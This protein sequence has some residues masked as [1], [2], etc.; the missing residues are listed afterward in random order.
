MSSK[1]RRL[2]LGLIGLIGLGSVITFFAIPRT[3]Y[4]MIDLKVGNSS[5]QIVQKYIANLENEIKT[6]QKTD[7]YSNQKAIFL[8]ARLIT[9]NH[10]ILSNLK[11]AKT[12]FAFVTAYSLV[13]DSKENLEKNFNSALMTKTYRFS[14]NDD[15]NSD[16]TSDLTKIA[17]SDT[18]LFNQDGGYHQWSNKSD[19]TQ[20][21]NGNV[22]DKFYDK[23]NLTKFYRGAIYIWGDDNEINQ[24]KTAWDNKNWSDFVKHGIMT[25]SPSSAGKFLLQQKLIKNHFS[26]SE[27]LTTL[28]KSHPKKIIF[29]QK[30]RDLGT[31]NLNNYHIV[32]GQ[33]NSFLWTKN[34]ANHFQLKDDQKLSVLT[35]TPKIPYDVG[36]FNKNIPTLQQKM[37][38]QAI[39]NLKNKGLDLFGP[40]I[41]Y[42]DY[43]KITD[44]GQMIVQ[45]IKNSILD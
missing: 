35:V 34:T 22:Y 36:V 17:E 40:T 27:N 24:I 41:G 43:E 44:H 26:L 18:N 20:K 15:F 19:G 45:Q 28:S 12:A 8:K 4:F 25:G 39:I 10:T 21:W 23:N 37:V 7:Q 9:D 38:T 42:H 5:L 13:N 16:Q 2:K 31:T 11:S 29:G 6:L 3:K 14:N 30:D 33:E 1:W 32:F